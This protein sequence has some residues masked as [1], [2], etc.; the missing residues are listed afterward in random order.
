MLMDW[1]EA[2]LISCPRSLRVMGYL[3]E[4]RH[5]QKRHDL[6]GAA[7]AEHG[8]RTRT[9]LRDA[10]SRCRDR[11]KAVVLGSGLLHDVPLDELSAGFREVILVDIL[12]PLSVRRRT[13]DFANVR[14][15]SADVTGAVES[16]Y[17]LASV[18]GA[19][20]P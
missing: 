16:V 3:R 18:P 12:H 7:W 5:I 6:W 14:L 4:L 8:E 9:I 10:V 1:L 19:S 17:R 20:L 13:R 11:R 15:L 2:L